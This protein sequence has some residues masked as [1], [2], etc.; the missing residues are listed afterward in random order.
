MWRSPPTRIEFSRH[1][2]PSRL[3]VRTHQSTAS[4]ASFRVSRGLY[5]IVDCLQRTHSYC[6]IMPPWQYPPSHIDSK[7]P[8]PY[9]APP[10]P[11]FPSY[12]VL[13]ASPLRIIILLYPSKLT[14]KH[15]LDEPYRRPLNLP[16]PL[17]NNRPAPLLAPK[18]AP[19]AAS[20]SALLLLLEPNLPEPEVSSPLPLPDPLDT[21]QWFGLLTG[22][23]ICRTRQQ[24]LA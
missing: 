2:E 22:F 15:H 8:L 13:F 19:K 20:L 14:Y 23:C 17:P 7:V 18:P 9:T 1:V 10:P 3:I 5:K 16:L 4:K 24:P 21:M 11:S 6:N 12:Q